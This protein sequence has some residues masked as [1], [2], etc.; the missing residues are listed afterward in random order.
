MGFILLNIS[1]CPSNVHLRDEEQFRWIFWKRIPHNSLLSIL[2][3]LQTDMFMASWFVGCVYSENGFSSFLRSFLPSLPPSFWVSS[4]F[5]YLW[6]WAY[7]SKDTVDYSLVWILLH[8]DSFKIRIKV[9]P[10]D[11]NSYLVGILPVSLFKTSDLVMYFSTIY[12]T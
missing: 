4:D 5:T 8:I 3:V 11:S 2:M 7:I 12:I 10:V 1:I 6:I 9:T